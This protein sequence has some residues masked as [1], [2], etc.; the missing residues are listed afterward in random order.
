M[1]EQDPLL[2]LFYT[3]SNQLEK[4]FGIM[5]L[6]GHYT[7]FNTLSCYG[8]LPF[9]KNLHLDLSHFIVL[10]V[11]LMPKAYEIE[12]SDHEIYTQIAKVF[13]QL[14]YKPYTHYVEL[15]KSFIPSREM[16]GK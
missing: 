12:C 3:L 6:F 7:G 5:W 13:P 10:K 14:T 16:E 1:S 9:F 15:F 11:T 2:A 8:T 4:R